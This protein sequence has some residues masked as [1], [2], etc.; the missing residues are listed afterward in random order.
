MQNQAKTYVRYTN[1]RVN[2]MKKG[3]RAGTARKELAKTLSKEWNVS[4]NPVYQKIHKVAAGLKAFKRK[5]LKRF[6]VVNQQIVKKNPM[7]STIN[8]VKKTDGIE[9][10]GD[11]LK[12]YNKLKKEPTK[13]V[14]HDDH[15]RYYFN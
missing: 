6:D 9:L 5:K 10:S 11:A 1:R 14:L 15:V 4:F 3:L 8:L 12:V 7:V 2:Q 13:I